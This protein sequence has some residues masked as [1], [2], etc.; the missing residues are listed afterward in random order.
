MAL[1]GFGDAFFFRE[2]VGTGLSIVLFSTV[3]HLPL[4][5]TVLPGVQAFL[6]AGLP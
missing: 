6:F 2:T 3:A 5:S 4:K 1:F